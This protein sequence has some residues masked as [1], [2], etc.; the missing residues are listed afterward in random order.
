MPFDLW[1]QDHLMR[2]EINFFLCSIDI[3]CF[4]YQILVVGIPTASAAALLQRSE[5]FLS[6]H[7]KTDGDW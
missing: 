7:L 1:D 4:C 2:Q 5:I 3:C 6:A